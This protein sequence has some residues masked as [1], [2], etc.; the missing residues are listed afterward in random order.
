MG[1]RL[2]WVGLALLA[3]YLVFIGGGWSGIYEAELRIATVA[4]AP[5]TPTHQ[6]YPRAPT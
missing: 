6:H 1:R 3:A 5:Q 4:L 2:A